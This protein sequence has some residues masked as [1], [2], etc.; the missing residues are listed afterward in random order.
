MIIEKITI[1]L[2]KTILQTEETLREYLFLEL[3]VY[4][5]ARLT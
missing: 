1:F 2:I 5:N 4:G 3:A